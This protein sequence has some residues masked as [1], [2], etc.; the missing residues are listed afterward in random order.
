MSNPWRGPWVNYAGI[1][2]GVLIVSYLLD[3][4]P[5]TWLAAQIGP[6][7]APARPMQFVPIGIVP[8]T[9]WLNI[10]SGTGFTFTLGAGNTW[11]SPNP[12]T[13]SPGSQIAGNVSPLVPTGH[14]DQA[15]TNVTGSGQ[16]VLSWLDYP[17]QVA[18]TTIVNVKAT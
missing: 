10:A 18:Q 5:W 16:I 12:V 8:E 14:E 17:N 11:A 7:T 1:A 2:G 3:A 6:K 9:L 15:W 13:Q 4:P